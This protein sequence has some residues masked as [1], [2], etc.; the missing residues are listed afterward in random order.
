LKTAIP[1][2]HRSFGNPFEK[3]GATESPALSEKADKS[4]TAQ[5][6]KAESEAAQGRAKIGEAKRG[7]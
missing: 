2:E 7:A 3:T 6:A 5:S 4:Q 1:H